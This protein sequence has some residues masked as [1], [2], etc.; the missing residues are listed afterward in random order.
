MRASLLLVLALL[1][2]PSAR[3]QP[4]A[5]VSAPLLALEAELSRT[6][7]ARDLSQLSPEA[8][9]AWVPGF[10]ARLDEAYRR[11]QPTPADAAMRACLLAR[12][13]EG[14]AALASVD[15]ALRSSSG[16]PELLRTKGQFLYDAGDY[17]GANA[18]A[19]QAWEASGRRDQGAFALLKMTEGRTRGGGDVDNAP[20]PQTGT[21]GVAAAATRDESPVVLPISANRRQAQVPALVSASDAENPP[22]SSPYWPWPAGWAL[23]LLGSAWAVKKKLDREGLTGPLLM[24]G[25]GVSLLVA[26]T[27]FP[28]SAPLATPEGL[29]FVTVGVGQAVTATAGS[30]ATAYGVKS[31]AEH[32]ISRAQGQQENANSTRGASSDIK[33][34]SAKNPELQRVIDKLFKPGDGSPGGTAGAARREALTGQPTKGRLHATAAKERL[35]WLRRVMRE[36]KLDSVDRATAEA[37]E[38]DLQSVVNLSPAP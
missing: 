36:Q 17:E 7:H 31:G 29:T 4:P 20:Q 15:Q 33:K 1:A 5:S 38:A 19:L 23:G 30:M 11:L 24:T 34:P 2:A 6:Q 14:E 22:A 10:R 18:A 13:G 12:L 8:Y 3:A 27:L 26:S 32:L 25:A 21:A 37:L 9:D 35:A 16:D 28:P